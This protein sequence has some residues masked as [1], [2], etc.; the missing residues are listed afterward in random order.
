MLQ[1]GYKEVWFIGFPFSLGF[2]VIGNHPLLSCLV[3]FSCLLSV[4]LACKCT[5]AH[6]PPSLALPPFREACVRVTLG[7]IG[8][9]KVWNRGTAWLVTV[10]VQRRGCYKSLIWILDAESTY[11]LGCG[12]DKLLL[13]SSRKGLMSS[14]DVHA[15]SSPCR[16]LDRCF[17]LELL[18]TCNLRDLR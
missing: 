3:L 7:I 5:R 13:Q 9:L 17:L 14:A 8:N 15:T 4:P 16:S 10:A 18:A 11:L 2:S 1:V 12:V 6:Q